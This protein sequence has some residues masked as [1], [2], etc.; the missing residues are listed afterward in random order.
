MS[1]FLYMRH[2]IRDRQR[3]RTNLERKKE[4]ETSIIRGLRTVGWPVSPNRRW[5]PGGVRTAVLL[6]KAFRDRAINRRRFYL[7][8][9]L[10]A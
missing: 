4:S 3:Y 1:P 5:T 6:E 9:V 10:T 2:S 8:Q 7:S